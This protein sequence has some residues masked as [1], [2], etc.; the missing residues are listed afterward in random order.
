MLPLECYS[1]KFL[2]SILQEGPWDSSS[3]TTPVCPLCTW[4]NLGLSPPFLHLVKLA[5]RNK[6]KT[7]THHISMWTLYP[8]K[9][10]C[11]SSSRVYHSSYFRNSSKQQH[12]YRYVYTFPSYTVYRR[13][14]WHEFCYTQILELIKE[15]LLI[16]QTEVCN[17]RAADT[18]FSFRNVI[19]VACRTFSGM[20]TATCL[21]HEGIG[22]L[23]SSL[24][25][26]LLP[27]QK[28]TTQPHF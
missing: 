14:V 17:W 19:L 26:R 25:P 22:W 21:L 10:T 27:M 9:L 8:N 4:L 3:V 18:G 23:F 24:A 13:Y 16:L 12:N 11:F 1:L 15:N 6:A 20:S 5:S 2:D 28:Y 7:T